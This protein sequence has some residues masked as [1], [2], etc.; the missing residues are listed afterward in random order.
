MPTETKT[1]NNYRIQFYSPEENG[2]G[3][4]DPQK[5]RF[6]LL[7]ERDNSTVFDFIAKVIDE[8][9]EFEDFILTGNV[10]RADMVLLFALSNDWAIE[11]AAGIRSQPDH[12]LK[13]V[14]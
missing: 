12:F 11:T 9:P 14:L 3:A 8:T 13:P 4:R 7:S 5:I 6:H 2:N 10:D 1:N